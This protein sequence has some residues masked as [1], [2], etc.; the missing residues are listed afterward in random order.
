[1]KLVCE[2]PGASRSN[3]SHDSRVRRR[4]AMVITLY[5]P[6]TRV[7]SRKSV[8]SLALCLVMDIVGFGVR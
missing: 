5:R 1:M 8:G 4:G 7:W 2:V 3:I 6:T